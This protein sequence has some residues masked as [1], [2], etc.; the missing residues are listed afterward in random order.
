LYTDGLVETP[1]SD[2]DTGLDRMRRHAL[3]LV[4]EPLDRLCGKV[5]AHLP[6]GSTDDVA[7]LAL[8]VPS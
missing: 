7:L 8:R 6:P 2:L 3:T 1:G 5:L 4:D